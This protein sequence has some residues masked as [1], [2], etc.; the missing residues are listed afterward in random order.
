MVQ[1]PVWWIE[2]QSGNYGWK[3][4]LCMSLFV[5]TELEEVFHYRMMH[6]GLTWE[7]GCLLCHTRVQSPF[8]SCGVVL[9]TADYSIS[10][11]SL[12]CLPPTKPLATRSCSHADIC[13]RLISYYFFTGASGQ[14]MWRAFSHIIERNFWLFAGMSALMRSWTVSNSSCFWWQGSSLPLSPCPWHSPCEL[15]A[16][17]WEWFLKIMCCFQASLLQPDWWV[18]HEAYAFWGPCP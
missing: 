18:L 2:G 17:F 15:F 13:L 16:P 5:E 11:T 14:T 8:T 10:P 12:A 9:G 1:R 6:F 7:N 3:G 4:R